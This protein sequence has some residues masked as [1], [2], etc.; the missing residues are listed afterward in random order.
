MEDT[1]NPSGAPDNLSKERSM[2]RDG[3]H[4][5]TQDQR[6][7]G[8]SAPSNPGMGEPASPLPPGVRSGDPNA[9]S[10]SPKVAGNFRFDFANEPDKDAWA[11]RKD[12]SK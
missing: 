11:N 9:W 1:R 7:A 8:P 6:P 5:P 12:I 4:G 2:L 3:R 10:A